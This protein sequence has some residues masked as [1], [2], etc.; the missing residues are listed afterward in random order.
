MLKVQPGV[1]KDGVEA[2]RQWR[3]EKGHA[4]TSCPRT[5][6]GVEKPEMTEIVDRSPKIL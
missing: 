2:L 6:A 1:G 4:P 3:A 5:R